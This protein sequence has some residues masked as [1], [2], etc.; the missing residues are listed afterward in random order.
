MPMSSLEVMFRKRALHKYV[1]ICAY[2]NIWKALFQNTIIEFGLGIAFSF[3][4]MAV[5]AFLEK[6]SSNIIENGPPTVCAE[7][8]TRYNASPTKRLNHRWCVSI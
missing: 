1:H 7:T 6:S 3:S 4:G 2:I 5:N 8:F